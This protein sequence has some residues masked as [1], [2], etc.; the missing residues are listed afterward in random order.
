MIS[1]ERV[2]FGYDGRQTLQ[3]VDAE[4]APGSFHFLTGPSGAGKTTLLR[5]LYLELSPR[6]GTVS[7]FGQ[8]PGQLRA[9]ARLMLR[10][11]IGIVFQ[12][13]RL[14]EHLSVADNVR[15][16]LLVHGRD[17]AEHAGDVAELI[18]WVGLAH[19]AEA[20]PR[21]LSAGEQQRA[22]IARAVI[23][24]PDVILAD[25]P[26]GNVDAEMGMRIL[27]LFVE[28]N[29]LGKTVVIATHDLGLIRSARTMVSTRILR[30]AD[31]R[32]NIGGE[33]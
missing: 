5:L 13:F 24:S 21:S 3:D 2:S 15:L 31:G 22:A 33:L 30:L 23:T 19:R 28:L 6:A 12:D 1:L 26:T 7:L 20:P 18:R 9:A 16:P 17:P 8:D 10:R 11:R 25:E 32:L 14:L 27:R 4:I 29:R